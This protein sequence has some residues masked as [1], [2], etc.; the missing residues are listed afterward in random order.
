M[1]TNRHPLQIDTRLQEGSCLLEVHGYVDI[2][3]RLKL[4]TALNEAVTAGERPVVVDLCEVE[5][6]DSTG[7]GVLLN[8]LRRLTRQR[9][10]LRL[11]CPPGR[12]RRVF[13]V[14]GL[15]GT[16]EFHERVEQALVN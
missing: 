14:A 15:E 8:A 7:I 1:P 13:E 16:F 9:R 11:V 5:F 6:I 10:A 12:V 2:S 4:S 3:T